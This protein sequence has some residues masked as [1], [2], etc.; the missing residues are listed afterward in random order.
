MCCRFFCSYIERWCCSCSIGLQSES[1][2]SAGWIALLDDFFF[3]SIH[4]PWIFVGFSHHQQQPVQCLCVIFNRSHWQ[5]WSKAQSKLLRERPLWFEVMTKLMDSWN[6]DVKKQLVKWNLRFFISL[7]SLSLTLFYSL[8]RSVYT[9]TV[10]GLFSSKKKLLLLCHG[11]RL[12]LYQ[13]KKLTQPKI[14][15]WEETSHTKH[16][17]GLSHLS[18][19]CTPDKWGKIKLL[20]SFSS[21]F[22]LSPAIHSSLVVAVAA[23]LWRLNHP[24]HQPIHFHAGWYMLNQLNSL[25]CAQRERESWNGDDDEMWDGCSWLEIWLTL[26]HQASLKLM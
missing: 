13:Y 16:T 17:T 25:I 15:I 1:L 9:P 18:R 21:S 8:R 22:F 19:V 14:Y 4:N 11:Y 10:V 26:L 3:L 5:C 7:F 2:V 6:H 12:L 23:K 20:N 24:N